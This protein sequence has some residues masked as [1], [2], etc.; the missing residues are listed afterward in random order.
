MHRHKLAANGQECKVQHSIPTIHSSGSDV[1]FYAASMLRLPDVILLEEKVADCPHVSD[2]FLAHSHVL[3]LQSSDVEREGAKETVAITI[4][5]S[6]E[7]WTC[8]ADFW[9]TR[10]D[11][12]WSDE[13]QSKC[14]TNAMLA[15]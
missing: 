4:N 10:G 13:L 8:Q 14:F 15:H 5:W 9:T 6:D 3:L 7:V 1:L 12:I 11:S 2:D